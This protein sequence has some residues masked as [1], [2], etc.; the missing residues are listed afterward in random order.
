MRWKL[1]WLEQF[2][3]RVAGGEAR[4][5]LVSDAENTELYSQW[6]GNHFLGV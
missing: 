1:A 6:D 5:G 4:N 2:A 3:K